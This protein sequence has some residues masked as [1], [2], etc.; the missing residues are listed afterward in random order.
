MLSLIAENKMNLMMANACQSTTAPRPPSSTTK[1][2]SHKQREKE[3]QKKRQSN[4]N[5]HDDHS[6]GKAKQQQKTR[7]DIESN[8]IKG[9][10]VFARMVALT[11]MLYH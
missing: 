7:V 8:Q 11:R 1:T 5:A 2:I 4:G 10:R 3:R 6:N 9:F